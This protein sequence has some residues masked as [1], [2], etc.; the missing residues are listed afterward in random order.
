MKGN[1]RPWPAYVRYG[2]WILVTAVALVLLYT[3]GAIP[4]DQGYYNFADRRTWLGIPNAADV[5]SNIPFLVVGIWGLAVIYSG[6][7][8][9]RARMFIDRAERLPYLAF[10]LGVGLVGFGSGW[11]HLNPNN[12]T[13]VWDRIPITVAF[14]S[15]FTAIIMERVSLKAGRFLLWPLLILG[16]LTVLYWVWTENRGNGDL[17]PYA[18][19]QYYPILAVPL[20]IALFPA[21]YTGTPYLLAVVG[22][23]GTAKIFELN[24]W[25]VFSALGW[26]SG[27]TIKHYLAAAAIVPIVLM[28]KSRKPQKG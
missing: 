4:Q 3:Q 10:F 25:A 7:A 8:E 1:N 21:R 18:F 26:I 24:D 11:F 20:L 2:T 23:Y 6:Q 28:L 13:L 22:L 14:V 19:I 5:L 17:R 16:I 12:S 9:R 27:H 15:F